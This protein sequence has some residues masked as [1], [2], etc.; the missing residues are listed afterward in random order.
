MPAWRQ[1][2]ASPGPQVSELASCSPG[3]DFRVRRRRRKR[4]N[5]RTAPPHS[6][7][8]RI[9]LRRHRYRWS[10][11]EVAARAAWWAVVCHHLLHSV[12]FLL[13]AAAQSDAPALAAESK[14]GDTWV[15]ALPG[16][17]GVGSPD[18]GAAADN[19]VGG[20]PGSILAR[21]PR[22]YGFPI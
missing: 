9:F 4:S 8:A 14:A 12:V 7:A 13:Q 18:A 17:S 19:T 10:R 15:A 2:Q 5:F 21:R 11:P 22:Q 16:T 20:N 6:V 3:S 1:L